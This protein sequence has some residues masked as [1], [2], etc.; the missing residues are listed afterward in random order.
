MSFAEPAQ[1]GFA[2]DGVE[3]ADGGQHSGAV[4]HV[5]GPMGQVSPAGWR[6]ATADGVEA[7]ELRLGVPRPRL[8]ADT[9]WGRLEECVQHLSEPFRGSEIAG[10]F[11][12]HY[13][14]VDEGS[15][16]THIQGATSNVSA[17]SRGGFARRRPL[18][19][20]ID[21]G[22]YTRYDRENGPVATEVQP[23]RER[24]GRRQSSRHVDIEGAV[25][26][27]LARRTP[28]A[29]YT[30]F[31]YC[32][33][34]FQ[35]NRRRMAVWYQSTGMEASCF[36]LAFYLASW[37]MLRGSSGLFQR[38]ARHLMPLIETIASAPDEVWNLD[39]DGYDTQGIDLILQ[40]AKDV[41]RALRPVEA[42]DILVSKV[43]LGVFGC[44][45]AFD[46][47]FKKG[48][49]V[50]TFGRGALDQIGEFYRANS[51][52]IESLRAPTLDF[53]T[54][55]PTTLLYTRAKVVDMAFFIEGGYTG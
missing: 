49:G 54:G 16:R 23:P 22:L 39:L 4:S 45:P 51:R 17:E 40:T 1:E 24:K 5:L 14:D 47:Y 32:F 55:K 31:D 11:R 3:L 18:I 41:R 6:E 44:V 34:H 26:A 12:R 8:A 30:S 36:H 35:Q 20:R 21:R 19:T 38:S 7:R 37:G 13:P 25:T 43:M 10:W 9:I 42:S 2:T 29:R 33:N 53:T 27:Y 52:L 50:S 15:L 48:F 28:D 46:T